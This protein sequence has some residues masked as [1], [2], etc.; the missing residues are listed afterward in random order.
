MEEYINPLWDRREKK[1]QEF[2][3]EIAIKG[4]EYLK[5]LNKQAIRRVQASNLKSK[6]YAKVQKEQLGEGDNGK[7]D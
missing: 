4:I 2:E 6:D 3:H 5:Q 1:I 7:K